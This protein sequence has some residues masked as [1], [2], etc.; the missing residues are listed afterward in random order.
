M[1]LPD[2]VITELPN[3]ELPVN[4]G[5]FP[6][7]PLPVTV[8]A[9]ALTVNN[10]SQHTNRRLFMCIFSQPLSL[11]WLEISANN[12]MRVAKWELA[13]P[14]ATVF[15]TTQHKI[16]VYG[17]NGIVLNPLQTSQRGR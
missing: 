16:T 14:K 7:V 12:L 8:C 3:V 10:I 17:P 1:L 4:T 11:L 13:Y 2:C 15:S 6:E 5:I 9:V